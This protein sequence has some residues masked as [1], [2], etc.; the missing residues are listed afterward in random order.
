MDYLDPRKQFRHRIIIMVGYVCITVAIIIGTIVL[1]IWL[2]VLVFGR[3]ERSSRTAG[4]F[5]QP[6]EPGDITML[7][8]PISPKNQ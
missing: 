3:M 4:I 1:V 2:M 8:S 5:F 6:S 7:A